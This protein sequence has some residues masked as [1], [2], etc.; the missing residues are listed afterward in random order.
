MARLLGIDVG[1]TGVRVAVLD[2]R[3]AVLA[4]ASE[5]TPPELPS[6]G[7]A[8]A[9]ADA[10]WA[11][12]IA[13]MG[14]VHARVSLEMIDAVGAVGQ[15]PTAI[16][17]D[18]GGRPLRSAIL[19]LDTR[20]E[21]EA[22]GLDAALGPGRAE[23]IGGN[24]MHAY[25]MGPKLAWLRA[26]D[27]ETLARARW[28]LQ[29]HAYVALRLTGEVGCDLSTAMLCAPLFDARSGA[30]SAEGAGAVGIALDRLPPILRAHDVLGAVTAEAARTTRLRP[31]TPVVAGGGDFA[32]SAL[33]AGVTE[34]GEACL[35]LGTAGNLL[36]PLSE[37]RFDSR[38]INSHHV[39]VE[40]WL[41][42]GG[43]LCGASLEWFRRTCAQGAT[44]QDLEREGAAAGVG[45]GGLIAIPYFQGERTPIWD[46]RARG[47]FFGLDLSH[48]RGHLF[49]AVVEG[50]A[51]G[52]RDCLAVAEG[53]G[54][55]VHEAVAINGA[56]KSALLRQTLCDALG[57]ALT[58]RDAA[59]GTVSGAAALAGLG[60][61]VLG[62]PS[63]VRAWCAGDPSERRH[64]P[65][66]R[67]HAA[68]NELLVRRRALYEATRPYL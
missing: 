68:L 51:L 37:P 63:A 38:L 41:A 35:M 34:V 17:V 25:Y 2:E 45:A 18:A 56:G 65:D 26:H 6:R 19:W 22:R 43:T 23:S 16:L 3:G 32:A 30:W 5:P 1:T 66:P 61:G 20:A 15:A 39:G 67:A 7:R 40:R 64:E 31:G 4:E 50:V 49:R 52:F 12:A 21:A 58:W 44:W 53:R 62:G 57:V 55:H 9:D 10:W 11:A 13:A 48:G 27:G 33:R 36:L 54:L 28:V 60:V 14:R 24:R 46:E 8:E 29:S 42:L 59:G 47:V